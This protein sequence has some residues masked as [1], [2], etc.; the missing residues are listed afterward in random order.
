MR[1]KLVYVPLSVDYPYWADDPN[2]D[3]DLHIHRL[4]LP[5]PRDWNTLRNM[6]ADIF[7]PPLDLRRPLWS[8]HFVEG[9]DALSQVPTGSVA[10][11]SKIHHVMI[12]IWRN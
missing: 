11:I 2:F 1:K 9:V 5:E 6:N 8:I 4:A 12:E 3:L 10:I 7:S